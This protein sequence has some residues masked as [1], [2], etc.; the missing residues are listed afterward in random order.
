[1]I[2]LF[3]DFLVGMWKWIVH[4]VKARLFHDLYILYVV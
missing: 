3:N 4:V 2:N 1:M